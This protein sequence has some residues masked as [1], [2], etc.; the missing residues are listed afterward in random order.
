MVVQQNQRMR[1]LISGS[2]TS[3]HREHGEATT[4]HNHVSMNDRLVVSTQL[5][6]DQGTY[7]QGGD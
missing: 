5:N 4:L 3:T 7:A 1:I 6:Q 2:R